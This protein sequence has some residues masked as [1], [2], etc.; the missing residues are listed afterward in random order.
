MG[1]LGTGSCKEGQHCVDR[2]SVLGRQYFGR[3]TQLTVRPAIKDPDPTVYQL[4]NSKS[5]NTVCLFTDF[6]SNT[7][8]SLQLTKDSEMFVSKNTVLDMKS[9]DSKSNGA[10]AWSNKT[11]FTCKS[12]FT[13]NIFFPSSEIPCDAK[14]VEKSFETDINL[15]FQNLSVMGLRILLLKVAGFNVLM[16]LR[17]WSN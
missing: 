4:R 14:L 6:D 10:L 5:R 17:L 12:A 2:G 8:V 3:G 11:D 1:T 9:M 7:N 15:N 13:Q 16:T